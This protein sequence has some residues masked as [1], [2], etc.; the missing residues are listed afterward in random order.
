MNE[1]AAKILANAALGI[2]ARLERIARFAGMV[3]IEI[4]H[5]TKHGQGDTRGQALW[6]ASQEGDPPPEP[7]MP[8]ERRT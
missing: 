6:K 3:W 2:A 4:Y 5:P 1:G 8:A 7:R